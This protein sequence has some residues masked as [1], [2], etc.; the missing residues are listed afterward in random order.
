MGPWP[1]GCSEH[2]ESPENVAGVN[3]QGRT[4]CD[5]VMIPQ[6]LG[7]KVSSEF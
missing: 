4:S 3:L 5:F 2:L 7:G 6:G 1:W